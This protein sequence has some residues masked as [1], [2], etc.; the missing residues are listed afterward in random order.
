[1][2]ERGKMT[3]LADFLLGDGILRVTQTVLVE[4]IDSNDYDDYKI[5]IKEFAELRVFSLSVTFSKEGQE[6]II[7]RLANS[8]DEVKVF[9]TLQSIVK[10]I[11]T[12]FPEKKQV[13]LELDSS[14]Q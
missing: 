12:A 6:P 7:A 9:K 4:M 10:L 13:V 2:F 8:R 3:P 1:M 11:K 14:E 5:I